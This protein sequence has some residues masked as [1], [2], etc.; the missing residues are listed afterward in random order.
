MVTDVPVTL[1]DANV[2][3]DV[4]TD[5]P[6]WGAWSMAQLAAAHDAGT[7]I[8]NPLVYAEVSVQVATIELLDE[9][10]V[11]MGRELLPFDAGFLAGRCF[12]AYR[13]RGGIRTSP[14]PDF[15][16][17]AHAAVRGHRLL[18][19]DATRYRTYF[20]GLELIAP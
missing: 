17:G 5:D 3:L 8:I 19:R 18:T 15:Y 13:R 10:L 4:I 11:E 12:L 6:Q 2:I 1:V 7:T 9:L 16:I 14:L 20:P